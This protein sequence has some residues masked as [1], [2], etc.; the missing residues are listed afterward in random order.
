MIAV[1]LTAAWLITAA[2]IVALC[3]AAALGD[4]AAEPRPGRGPRACDGRLSDPVNA[5]IEPARRHARAYVVGRAY[6]REN[7]DGVDARRVYR[8]MIRSHTAPLG[9]QR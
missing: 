7:P 5:A 4:T 2:L 8:R 6:H 1:V 3:R 9:G